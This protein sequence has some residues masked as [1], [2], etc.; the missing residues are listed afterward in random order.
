MKK[1]KQKRKKRKEEEEEEEEEDEEEDGKMERTG[2]PGYRHPGPG[3]TWEAFAPVACSLFT[4][5]HPHTHTPPRSSID[6]NQNRHTRRKTE[7][8]AATYQRAESLFRT[9]ENKALGCCC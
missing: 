5:Q 9:K 4:H 7:R 8:A 2:A 3:R 1:R 6:Q